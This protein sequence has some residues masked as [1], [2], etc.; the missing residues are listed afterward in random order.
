M[1]K[2]K[3]IITAALTG[4]IHTPT[5]SAALPYTAEAITEQALAAAAAGAAILH[6]HA[7]NPSNGA[8][9]IKPA[10]FLGFL[11][12]IKEGCDAVINIS[13]GGS[14]VNTMAERIAPAGR[15]SPEMCSLNMGSIN[16]AF[17]PLANRYNKWQYD[18]EEDYV[19][20]S[21]DYI[22]RNTFTDIAFV[23]RELGSD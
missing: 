14:L 16:F 18:W 20:N 6:L 3:T 13:T 22:F 1:P 21:E 9:S 10:D 12:A 8:P 15:F 5:M 11:P 7:R 23:A 17:H 19:R 4:A 2:R